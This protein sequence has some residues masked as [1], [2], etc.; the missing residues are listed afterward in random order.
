MDIM[1]LSQTQSSGLKVLVIDDDVFITQILK[2]IGEKLGCVID[3]IHDGKDVGLAM[4]ASE[5]DIIFLDLVLPNIDGVEII[6]TLAHLNVEAKLVLMSGLDQRTLSS[7]SSVAKKHNLDV[8]HTIQKPF[9][10]GQVEEILSPLISSRLSSSPELK[11]TPKEPVFGP[12]LR[13]EPDISFQKSAFEEINWVRTHLVWL[14]NNYQTMDMKTLVSS[15]FIHD[16]SRGLIEFSIKNAAIDHVLF[17]EAG[18]NVGFRL[19]VSD[20]LL[21]DPSLPEFLEHVTTQNNLSPSKLMLEISETAIAG[22]PEV[23]LNTL[24]RL[25]IKGFS[26]AICVRDL[27]EDIL[28]TLQTLPV[29]ELLI[30]MS[31]DSFL[32]GNLNNVETEFQ[33]GSLASYAKGVDLDTSSKHVVSKEQFNLAKHC[34]L[35]KASGKHISPAIDADDLIEFYGNAT[36]MDVYRVASA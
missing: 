30:D 7:V 28:E 8:I 27:V 33:L 19:A 36:K 15:S 17:E 29:D 23:T 18:A 31:G 22:L 10:P 32:S 26:L 1:R 35:D 3:C 16:M 5:P 6:H 9:R 2:S 13:Y 11:D 20:D 24:A 34:L 12:R 14:M 4:I 21:N 25:K